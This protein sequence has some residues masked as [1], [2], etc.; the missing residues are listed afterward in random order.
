MVDGVAGT[1][2]TCTFTYT[3]EAD[4][5]APVISLSGNQGATPNIG[6]NPS[7]AQIE[8][9]LGSAT[10]TDNCDETVT[11]SSSDGTV[12]TNGCMRTV[13]RTFNASDACTNAATAVTR[14]VTYKVDV[15][16]PV[17]TCPANATFT[18]VNSSYP[19]ILET[20][21]AT[22]ADNCDAT[23]QV[24]FTDAVSCQTNSTRYTITRTFVAKDACG[25]NSSCQQTITVKRKVTDGCFT[26]ELKD[27]VVSGSGVNKNTTF[28]YQVCA[29]NN[30]C[31]QLS[32]VAFA[33]F[34]NQNISVVSPANGYTYFN[35]NGLKEYVVT[36]PISKTRSGTT[37]GI[38]YDLYGAAA[39]PNATN[40]C[41]TFTFTMKGEVSP[42][43]IVVQFKAG[44]DPAKNAVAPTCPPNSTSSLP[45]INH[46]AIDVATQQ[47]AVKALAVSASPNP[48][49]DRIRFTIQ[50][51]K[52]GRA[53]L[54][55]YNMLGQ[56]V[57]V[58][59]EGQL[60]AN[61]TRTVEFNAPANHRSNLIYTLRMNGEQI[62]GK[63]MSIKQ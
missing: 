33:T 45:G 3:I 16:A 29:P 8:A 1:P 55:V 42:D 7:A 27:Y 63:L 43:A 17:I 25:N 31:K 32:Y 12:Q 60:N 9:A 48:F 15:T 49:T 18:S 40:S 4:V 14:T 22:A 38:K 26:A 19:G 5:T 35:A 58:A 41:Y 13:T 52:A 34:F 62:S 37:Y 44:S 53:T 50:A 30:K 59:F 54:E 56:K 36:T 46:V 24:T 11:V 39:I 51:P 61:E 2:Q 28:T 47:I 57:G 20:G 23:P 10:A 6:C 21:T